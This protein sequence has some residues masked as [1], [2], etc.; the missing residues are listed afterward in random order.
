MAKRQSLKEQVF[1]SKLSKATPTAN[2]LRALIPYELLTRL[3]LETGDQVCWKLDGK[4]TLSVWKRTKKDRKI[5]N[6]RVIEIKQQ[7][8]SP[9]PV[10]VHHI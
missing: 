10:I 4:K 1:V 6:E 2:S 3:K 9:P 5:A 8:S 7:S